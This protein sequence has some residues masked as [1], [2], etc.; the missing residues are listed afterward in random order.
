[1]HDDTVIALALA[2]SACGDQGVLGYIEFLKA[3]QRALDAR[4]DPFA[5]SPRR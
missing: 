2:W 1:M 3:G 5:R 4:R